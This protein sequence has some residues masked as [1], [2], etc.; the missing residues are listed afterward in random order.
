MSLFRRLRGAILRLALARGPAGATGAILA[1][2]ALAL[3]AFDFGW[4]SALTDGLS[5]V[6]G[7]TGVAL[8][9]MAVSGRKPDW[10][11]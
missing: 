2:A 6:L 4:E 9:V 8:I 7:A 10:I 3:L 1:A 5:L 11:E